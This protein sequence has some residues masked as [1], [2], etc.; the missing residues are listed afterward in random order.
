MNKSIYQVLI[1]ASLLTS[2][3][4]A[5]AANKFD[6][7][8]VA[9]GDG[10]NISDGKIFIKPVN[11]NYGVATATTVPYHLK[12]KA[13]CKRQNMLKQVFVSLGSENV[14]KEALEYSDNYRHGVPAQLN[15]TL[16]W[17][18]IV[19][20]IPMAKLGFN[21][22][23]MCQSNLEQKIS[24]GAN[25]QQVMSTDQ[26]LSKGV[27]FTAV[28]SCGK[29]GKTNDHYG[30][31]FIGAEMKVI[32]KAGSVA[33][34][35]DIQMQPATPPQAPAGG[36]QNIGQITDF[37][38]HATPYKLTS[39]CP[40]KAKFTGNITVDG[41]VTVKYRV[42]F[43]GSAKTGIRTL[44]FTKAGSHTIGVAEYETASSIP[45]GSAA[46]EIISP[47]SKKA[48]ANFKVNCIAAG[49][50]GS[51]Q[52]QPAQNNVPSAGLIKAAPAVKID[53]IRTKPA[54][55]PQLQ[56]NKS[57]ITPPPPRRLPIRTDDTEP[58]EPAR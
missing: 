13:G 26:V 15:K 29:L 42:L 1:I 46:L 20:N 3:D 56:I 5:L 27:W 37:N 51:I 32:C 35:N 23:T 33:G 25:K 8:D 14:S 52:L 47:V 43:P 39:T 40:A 7:I 18:N 38:I 44:K 28:A 12:V 50:P 17:T 10:I 45:V 36:F 6:Y 30:S 48:F 16:P 31:K 11:G 2:A 49:G 4:M 58:R 41:P 21:P 19:M 24:Q 55:T 54:P 9:K 34:I 53:S 22:A 57:K